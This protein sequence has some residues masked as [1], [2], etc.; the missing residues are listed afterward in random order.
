M[1]DVQSSKNLPIKYQQMRQQKRRGRNENPFFG[2]AD[3][4]RV[5]ENR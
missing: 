4:R 5:L 3:L 1:T 2:H